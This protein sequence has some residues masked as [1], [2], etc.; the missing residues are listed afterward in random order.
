MAPFVA[1]AL[2]LP[3]TIGYVGVA[4]S[5]VD[6]LQ[7]GFCQ[8]LSTCILSMFVSAFFLGRCSQF[9]TCGNVDFISAAALSRFARLMQ[10]KLPNHLLVVHMLVAQIIFTLLVGLFLWAVASLRVL[11][12]ASYLPYPVL[13]GFTCASGLMI[14]DGGLSLGS[15]KGLVEIVAHLSGVD[16]SAWTD[17]YAQLSATLMG[18]FAF[19]VLSRFRIEGAARLP[20]GF[21]VISAIFFGF[22]AVCNVSHAELTHRGFFLSN[23]FSDA[24]YASFFELASNASQIDWSFWLE[25]EA[26]VVLLPCVILSSFSTIFFMASLHE[27]MPPD[28]PQGQKYVFEDEIR[29]QGRLNVLIGLLGGTPV[30][31]SLKFWLVIKQAGTNSR[32]WVVN[33]GLAL[34][35]LFFVPDL[36]HCLSVVP[37][38]AFSGLVVCV[39]LEW[40]GSKFWESRRRIAAREWR[41]AAVTMIVTFFNLFTGILLGILLTAFLFLV[42]YSSLTGIVRKATLVEVRSFATWAPEQVAV[43]DRRGQEVLVFWCSGYIFFGT[44]SSIVK[45]IEE[46][47]D[48]EQATRAVIIDF[49]LVPAV[50]ASGIRALMSFAGACASSQ[51]PVRV[52]YC[53]MT[54]RLRSAMRQAIK[55]WEIEGPLISVDQHRIES[56]LA[57]AE[58]LLIGVY[59]EVDPVPRQRFSSGALP[60]PVMEADSAAKAVHLVCQSLAPGAPQSEVEAFASQVIPTSRIVRNQSG[61]IF[62]WEGDKVS[63]LSLL[64]TGGVSLSKATPEASDFGRHHLNE[65]KGDL[66][67]FE[68]RTKV[69]LKTLYPGCW[70]GAVQFCATD[71]RTC[72]PCSVFSARAGPGG[73]CRLEVPFAN[74]RN[75][76]EEHPAVG[77]AVLLHISSIAGRESLELLGSTQMLPYRSSSDATFLASVAASNAFSR[78]HS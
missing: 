15:G 70:L 12:V 2:A 45:E 8:L 44:A 4:I 64:L 43:L 10:R 5:G 28:V 49:E 17:G 29:T 18:A 11:W 54:R 20:I 13:I 37:K 27:S 60:A 52:C 77:V 39:G 50:D 73:S 48:A 62:L 67:V 1:L 7:S 75:A 59:R 69:E 33:M 66:F 55:D 26:L 30:C 68:E 78:C 53:G 58:Q 71:S 16:D 6:A 41:F 22:A 42:E 32:I 24:W 36:R 9:P 38:C 47:L 25:A 21:L 3:V 40:F 14:V 72:M 63:S 35:L 46:Q 74:L 56:A 19:V 51:M 61:E 76:I 23:I 31:S 65:K 57:W 34:S